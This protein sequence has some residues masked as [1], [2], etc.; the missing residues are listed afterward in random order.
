MRKLE[1]NKMTGLYCVLVKITFTTKQALA[2]P[3][4]PTMAKTN[5]C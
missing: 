4:W 2:E 5:E 3:Y 1:D